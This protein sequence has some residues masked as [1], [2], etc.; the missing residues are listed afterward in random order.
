MRIANRM[1]LG[2]AA[3]NTQFNIKSISI[4]IIIIVDRVIVT[5]LPKLPELIQLGNRKIVCEHLFAASMRNAN[6]MGK[7]PAQHIP[8][9]PWRSGKVTQ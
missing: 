6:I 2:S 7:E 8:P 5:L 1:P 9:R 3:R 4:N